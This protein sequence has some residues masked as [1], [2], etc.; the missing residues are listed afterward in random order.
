MG[1]ITLKQKFL[2]VSVT[3]AGFTLHRFRLREMGT[4]TFAVD[5]RGKHHLHN[6]V[7]IDKWRTASSHNMM[8]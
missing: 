2:S 8:D 3:C 5:C 4:L 1:E 6:H 7:F